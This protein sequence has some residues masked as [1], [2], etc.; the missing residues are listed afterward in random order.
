[1]SAVADTNRQPY[2]APIERSPAPRV[3]PDARTAGASVAATP[4]L[5]G[6]NGGGVSPLTSRS[7]PRQTDNLRQLLFSVQRSDEP[8]G[9]G[10]R[11][12]DY[13]A[14]LEG[15]IL[16]RVAGESVAQYTQDSLWQPM[17]MEY[18]ASW[19]LDSTADG[20]EKTN[21]GLDARAIDFARI[22]RM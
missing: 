2:S 7:L 10:F 5:H 12:N 22:G 14:L 17:G 3:R 6:G 21:T 9:T 20:V 18:P 13:Y 11:Y 15:L 8:V 1:M 19:S 16:Q 4:P